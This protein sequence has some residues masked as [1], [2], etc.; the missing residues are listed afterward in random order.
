MTPN[1]T[2]FVSQLSVTGMIGVIIPV[3]ESW[4]TKAST[5]KAAV[6]PQELW[7]PNQ[8]SVLIHSIA[9]INVQS[10][11]TG[12]PSLPHRPATQSL[13]AHSWTRKKNTPNFSAC[14][15]FPA[16]KECFFF[17]P[18]PRGRVS[19]SKTRRRRRWRRRALILLLMFLGVTLS[20]RKPEG[21]P[22]VEIF[23]KYFK[24]NQSHPETLTDA[25]RLLERRRWA[26]VRV[27]GCTW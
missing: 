12:W 26:P 13:K 7:L 16:Y 4:D 17:K 10:N 27:S 1:D 24:T 20:L 18:I 9:S 11:L 5:Q 15:F 3:T 14:K 2:N 19:W 23:W 6:L 22:T 21:W 25:Q 8:R